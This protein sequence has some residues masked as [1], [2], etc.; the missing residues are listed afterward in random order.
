M[1][2]ADSEAKLLGLADS[3]AKMKSKGQRQA[4]LLGFEKHN[5]PELTNLLRGYVLSAFNARKS[6]LENNPSSSTLS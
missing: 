5:G 1:C 4:F 2:K 3:I 6:S